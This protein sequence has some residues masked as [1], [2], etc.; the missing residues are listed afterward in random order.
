MILKEQDS[1]SIIEMKLDEVAKISLEENPTT[2]YLWTIDM[3]SGLEKIDDQFIKSE[4]IGS[5]GVRENLFRAVKTGLSEL[6]MKKWREWEGESS[7]IDRF[8]IKINVK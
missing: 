5:S 2:G 6:K 1:G 7:V 8:S 4:A 3:L